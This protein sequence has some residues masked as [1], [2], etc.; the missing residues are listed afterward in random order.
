MDLF[1]KIPKPVKLRGAPE[2]IINHLVNQKQVVER[3]ELIK[4]PTGDQLSGF[5]VIKVGVSWQLAQI[6]G[7][8]NND[9]QWTNFNGFSVLQLFHENVPSERILAKLDDADSNENSAWEIFH[10]VFALTWLESFVQRQT[11]LEH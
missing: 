7:K 3:G 10:H 4:P 6:L 1:G 2:V 8:F 11:N 9:D 5:I